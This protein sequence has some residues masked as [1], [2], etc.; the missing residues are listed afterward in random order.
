MGKVLL[1]V[2]TIGTAGSMSY[3]EDF[4]VHLD[5]LVTVDSQKTLPT[6]TVERKLKKTNTQTNGG[7]HSV[8]D[9]S[10]RLESDLSVPL[11]V[12]TEEQ[13]PVG[14]QLFPKGSKEQ[15]GLIDSKSVKVGWLKGAPDLLIVAWVLD[16]PRMGKPIYIHGY[17]ILQLKDGKVKVLLRRRDRC[18]VSSIEGIH[19]DVLQSARFSWDTKAKQLVETIDRSYHVVGSSG[20][21]L[22][23]HYQTDVSFYAATIHETVAIRYSLQNDK[24]IPKAASLVYTTQKNTGLMRDSLREIARF[25]L[26]P[27]AP[28]ELLLNANPK[29]AK[30]HKN[31]HSGEYIHLPNETKVNIPVPAE[32][33]IKKFGT[34]G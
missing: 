25:Y 8:W 5:R 34:T 27:M 29:L 13:Y 1:L 6:Y 24:L 4:S 11:D 31:P 7:T 17:L 22:T 18:G 26:G 15:H 21:P 3:G 30:K 10:I 32:W 28:S 33:L 14:H 2:L 16:P 19:E 23:R 12:C 9:V 20:L